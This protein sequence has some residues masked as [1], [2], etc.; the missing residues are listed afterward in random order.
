M[1]SYRTS[2]NSA[3]SIE[4]VWVRSDDGEGRERRTESESAG[5]DTVG[6]GSRE[7]IMCQTRERG[8]Q[9]NEEHRWH[10]E[11]QSRN[12]AQMSIHIVKKIPAKRTCPSADNDARH[13]SGSAEG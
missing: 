11:S 5:N 3:W 12:A 4:H 9:N 7:D 6:D 13:A 1:Q 10:D 2:G 8:L